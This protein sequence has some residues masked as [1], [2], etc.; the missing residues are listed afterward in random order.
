MIKASE[1]MAEALNDKSINNAS[2]PLISNVLAQEVVEANH[3]K[4]LLVEQVVSGVR[5]RESMEYLVSKGVNEVI[6]IGNGEVL[7]GL[8]KRV[9]SEV[10]RVNLS[11]PESIEEFMKN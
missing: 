1:A 10:K 6:E 5:W 3:I 9:D 8:M 2:I 4:S 11:T 7:T